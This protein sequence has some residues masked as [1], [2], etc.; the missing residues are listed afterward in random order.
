MIIC[1]AKLKFQKKGNYNKKNKQISY[2]V[3]LSES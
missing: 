3:I 2:I 1:L